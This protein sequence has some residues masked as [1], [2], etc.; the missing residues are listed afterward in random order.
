MAYS[1]STFLKPLSQT[2]TSIQIMDTDLIIRWTV[3]PFTVNNLYVQNNLVKISLSSHRE[4]VIDFRTTN[5]AK[6]AIL[7]LKSVLEVL[8]NKTPQ[9]IDKIIEEYINGIGLSYSNGNLYVNAN[10]I[11]GLT[12][13]YTIGNYQTDWKDLFVSTSS[14][15]IGGVTL[16]SDGENLLV[17]GSLVSGV[18]AT[19]PQGST[20]PAGIGGVIVDEVILLNNVTGGYSNWTADYTSSGGDVEITAYITGYVS[21]T[22]SVTYNL[23]RDGIV[24][25][26][27]SFYFNPSNTHLPLPPIKYVSYSET[28]THTWSI[29]SDTILVDNNDY[30]LMV[31][32]E[33]TYSNFQG[34]QGDQGEIGPQGPQG[35]AVGSGARFINTILPN[36]PGT[37]D[38]VN[39]TLELPWPYDSYRGMSIDGEYIYIDSSDTIKHYNIILSFQIYN[40]A[41]ESYGYS[42][43]YNTGSGTYSFFDTTIN[44][45]L[46]RNKRQTFSNIIRV[47]S[48]VTA[49]FY[50]MRYTTQSDE[51]NVLG[52]FNIIEIV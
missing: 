35:P 20:G 19:G 15:Y 48:G 3:N 44:G 22:S 11:P 2:D 5:E 45:D 12:N 16:S 23:L 28:G 52:N 27:S 17:N 38:P 1:L 40:A 7:R 18:G 25:A 21:N 50:F 37:T 29:N 31:A 6:E 24:V 8:R 14:I 13:T 9:Y 39:F 32:K 10:L 26:T 51:E 34:P 4:I 46:D 49:S 43:K 42:L 33:S 47:P 30:C 36:S 41:N